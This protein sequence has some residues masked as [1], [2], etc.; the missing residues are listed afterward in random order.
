MADTDFPTMQ[1]RTLNARTVNHMMR[2]VI[3]F[4]AKFGLPPVSAG[5]TMLPPELQAFREKFMQEELNEYKE[6]VAE[7]DMENAFDALLDLMYVALGTIYL[8]N[9][10]LDAGWAEVQRANMSKVRVS[11]AEDSKRKSAFDVV[12]PEGWE[13][14]NHAPLLEFAREAARVGLE[15]D[16]IV[17]AGD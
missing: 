2:D 15:F 17:P 4:H 8:H 16:D 11:R 3:A 12:K 5:P 7:G 6:A 13:P 14:P 1:P 9:F 10:P